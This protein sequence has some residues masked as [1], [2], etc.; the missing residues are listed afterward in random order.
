MKVLRGILV[1]EC[2]IRALIV[3]DAV[4]ADGEPAEV[5]VADVLDGGECGLHGLGRVEPV[6]H[7]PG[8]RQREKG[9]VP[10]ER[11]HPLDGAIR[12]MRRVGFALVGVPA[13]QRRKRVA[14]HFDHTGV[15]MNLLQVAALV[16][17]GEPDV[18]ALVDERPEAVEI[19]APLARGADLPEVGLL[20][21]HRL[22]AIHVGGL[23]RALAGDEDVEIVSLRRRRRRAE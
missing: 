17:D 3:E 13:N 15:A 9:V 23:A 11:L 20:S 19:P 4:P 22:D 10:V 6:E 2:A 18:A 7:S 12:L 14:M 16:L 8:R 5:V 1:A 21:S